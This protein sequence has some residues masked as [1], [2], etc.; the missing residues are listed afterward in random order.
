MAQTIPHPPHPCVCFMHKGKERVIR[1]EGNWGKYLTTSVFH[2]HVRT[3]MHMHTWSGRRFY[4]RKHGEAGHM[5]PLQRVLGS[6]GWSRDFRH[7]NPHKAP[8]SPLLLM[9]VCFLKLFRASLNFLGPSKWPLIEGAW[10]DF[11]SLL[12]IPLLF[13]AMWNYTP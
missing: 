3:H 12:F 1:W 9:L 2:T 7:S 8:L 4:V 5:S 13:Y 10:Q 11:I 6:R